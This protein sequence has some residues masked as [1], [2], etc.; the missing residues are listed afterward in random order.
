MQDRFGMS[1]YPSSTGG[2]API[3]ISPVFLAILAVT[4]LAGIVIYAM[5]FDRT[6]TS[7]VLIIFVVGGWITSLCLHEFGH[8]F[9]AYTGGDH[10]VVGKGYLTLNPLRY[11]HGL[12]S[13]VFP[14][15]FLA[16]GGI[17]L[18]GGA[19]YINP[20]AIKTKAMR[21]FTSAAGPIATSIC[22][23]VLLIPF[24]TGIYQE[25]LTDHLAFWAGLALLAFLQITALFFNLLPIPG[26]DGFGI[27]APYLPEDFMK[28]VRGLG[29]FT[30]LIIFFLFF[31]GTPISRAFWSGI[32]LVISL[33][34]L[35]IGLVDLGLNLF[36][37]WSN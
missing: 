33:F 15:V 35:D 31:G 18:P 13:I 21:S 1:S 27:L 29:M 12:L 9:V 4:V 32:F 16:M 37:F 2:R 23:I 6:L 30:Y 26:L 25:T 36:Q 34:K 17:G 5:E 8:A 7:I 28:A 10:G 14:L 22:A 20:G 24:L 11:T 3:S 19:V